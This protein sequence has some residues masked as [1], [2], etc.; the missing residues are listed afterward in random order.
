MGV[1]SNY[2]GDH[3]LWS[4]VSDFVTVTTRF[5]CYTRSATKIIYDQ[6]HIRPCDVPKQQNFNRHVV[7]EDVSDAW[8]SSHI[9]FSHIVI[10]W[11]LLY[12]IDVIIGSYVLEQTW[13]SCPCSHRCH[14][15]CIKSLNLRYLRRSVQ[16]S[17]RN[18]FLEDEDQ[19][20]TLPILNSRYRSYCIAMIC[21]SCMVKPYDIEKQH[22]YITHT[23]IIIY[24]YTRT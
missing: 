24:I 16:R 14:R 3:Y 12:Y 21:C 10:I 20:L 4:G 15:I 6:K 11:Y 13:L 5:R 7:L 19:K 8:Y 22:V 1:F 18:I 17:Q 23:H 2:T 9:W